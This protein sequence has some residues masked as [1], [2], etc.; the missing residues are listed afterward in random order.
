VPLAM[1]GAF[2]LRMVWYVLHGSASAGFSF[3]EF[4][5]YQYFYTQCR[6]IWLYIRLFFLP[7]GQNVDHDFAISRTVLAHGALV[8]LAALAA[9]VAAAIY[10]RRRFPL[11]SYGFLAFLLLLAPT[12]SFVP[13]A[14]VAVERRM[15]LAFFGLL[16]VTVEFLR[17]WKAGRGTV[18]AALAGVLLVTGYLAYARNG[19]WSSAGALWVDAASKSPHKSRPQFQA[20]FAYFAEGRCAEALPYFEAAARY[21]RYP[22]YD[23]LVDWAM[24]YEC[25]SRHDEALAKLGQAAGL[26]PGA[27][28]Y[29]MIGWVYSRQGKRAEALAAF[30]MA[31]RY[32]AA[33]DSAY[34]YRGDVY[35][36][37]NDLA[38]AA[39]DYRRALSINPANEVAQQGLAAI[40]QRLG[41][42]H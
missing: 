9:G 21:D 26:R 5:W 10:Y 36:A 20:G 38:A 25:L 32:D 8:G 18:L 39:T 27:H 12:S 33:F 41:S 11:A 4:T 3:R 22:G 14:D 28:A 19:V 16:L 24:A 15:Y 35:A 2:A 13:I 29:T 17:R 34:A 7:F 31:L 30:D 40:E 1:V 6:A 42:L 37:A 23:V